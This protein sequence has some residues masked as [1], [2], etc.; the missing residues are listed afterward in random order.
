M[1]IDLPASA[2]A[3]CQ[4]FLAL[5]DRWNQTHSLTSL[6]PADRFEEL[7]LDS[8]VLIPFLAALPAGARVVDFGSGMGIPAA[9]LA[10]ARPDLEILALDKS[11]KKMAFVRQAGLELRLPS[12]KPIAARAEALPALG[13]ALGVSKAVGSPALLASW[14][15]RHGQPGAPLFALKSGAWQE[16][17]LPEGPWFT[18][19]HPYRLPTRG[20]RVVLEMRKT[21]GP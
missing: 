4:E 3:A 8:W 17:P 15:E 13:A 6:S 7:I 21:S 1:S 2:L 11:H 10:I 5:L 9:V 14:W 20:E 16:E 19:A 18:Q 12:L